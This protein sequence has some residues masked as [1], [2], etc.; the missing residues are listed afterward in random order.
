MSETKRR[1]CCPPE[2]AIYR[3]VNE[4]PRIKPITGT[5]RILPTPGRSQS[6]DTTSRQ[7][8]EVMNCEQTVHPEFFPGDEGQ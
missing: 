5:A 7:S 4:D 3:A 1:G 6:T 2:A 8:R